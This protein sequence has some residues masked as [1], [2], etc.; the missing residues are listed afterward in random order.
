MILSDINGQ[1]ECNQDQ[2]LKKT[3]KEVEEYY[4]ENK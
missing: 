2:V 4:E 3:L 1:S